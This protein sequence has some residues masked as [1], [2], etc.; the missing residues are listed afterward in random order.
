MEDRHGLTLLKGQPSG[1]W[2][3]AHNRNVPLRAEVWRNFE[4]EVADGWANVWSKAVDDPER[5]MNITFW[6]GHTEYVEDTQA[7]M[8]ED[9]LPTASEMP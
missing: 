1:W 6:D 5:G 2:V 4:W 9:L 8:D 3:E 7:L